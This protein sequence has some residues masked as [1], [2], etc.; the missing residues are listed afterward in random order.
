MEE[1]LERVSGGQEVRELVEDRL[2]RVSGG[3]VRDS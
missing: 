2:E 3:Q 1:R